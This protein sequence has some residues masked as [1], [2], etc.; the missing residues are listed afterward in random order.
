MPSTHPCLPC[1][2]PLP[3][4]SLGRLFSWLVFLV[5]TS[6][7]RPTSNIEFSE[8]RSRPPTMI[9][10][11]DC[12]GTIGRHTRTNNHHLQL[13][14]EPE[15]KAGA[16]MVQNAS[17][18]KFSLIMIATH[19]VSCHALFCYRWKS[20]SLRSSSTRSRNIQFL[21]PPSPLLTLYHQVGNGRQCRHLL[22]KPRSS[23]N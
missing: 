22:H 21:I 11:G 15:P 18:S 8:G 7:L 10:T 20:L 6:F 19:F 9:A 13:K 14:S 4:L 1:S 17:P 16:A 5:R 3:L 2:F 23:I 12:D